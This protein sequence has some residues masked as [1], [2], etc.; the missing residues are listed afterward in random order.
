[1]VVKGEPPVGGR[2][3]QRRSG[4]ARPGPVHQRRRERRASTAT[5]SGATTKAAPTRPAPAP[6]LQADRRRGQAE[7]PG[8]RSGRTGL[9]RSPVRLRR[10]RPTTPKTTRPPEKTE[11]RH[12]AAVLPHRHGLRLGRD[13]HRGQK[14]PATT[15]CTTRSA[16]A[17]AGCRPAP[18]QAP[19]TRCS[20]AARPTRRPKTPAPRRSTTTPTT[21]TSSRP[22]TPTR[23][24]RSA[25]TTPAGCHYVPTGTVNP[26]SQVHR[27]VTDPMASTSH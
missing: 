12:R 13:D 19:P 3:S 9:R 11:R 2:R 16:P 21:S 1:M 18:P 8:Q 5:W 20:W 17:P 25:A 6:G 22:R 14:S 4:Q 10:S 23:A 7:H 27:W 15:C 24:C 26:E